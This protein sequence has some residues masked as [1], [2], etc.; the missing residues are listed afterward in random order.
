MWLTF[1][2]SEHIGETDVTRHILTK[3]F[4]AVPQVD[5]VFL[6]LP[7]TLKSVYSPLATFFSLHKLKSKSVEWH[8]YKIALCSRGNNVGCEALNIRNAL[9]EDH[10]DLIPIFN[11]QSELLPSLS[12]KF[13]LA[14]LI[15]NHSDVQKTLVAEVEHH[16]VF[17]FA[18]R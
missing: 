18:L 7:A 15:E 11:K 1:F 2:A 5:L 14:N 16:I 13:F 9:V 12:D 4:E 6:L 3:A 8:E 10:D 17:T